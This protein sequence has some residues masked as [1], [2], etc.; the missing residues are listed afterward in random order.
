M[1]DQELTDHYAIGRMLHLRAL[2]IAL[3]EAAEDFD[4]E[5]NHNT[6]PIDLDIAKVCFAHVDALVKELG[7]LLEDETLGL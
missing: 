3:R 4:S 6:F 7:A 1:Q 2:A 5:L